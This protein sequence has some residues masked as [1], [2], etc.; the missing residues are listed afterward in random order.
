MVCADCPHLEREE[1][2]GHEAFYRCMRPGEKEG[3]VVA[4][5]PDWCTAAQIWKAPAWCGYGKVD[6]YDIERA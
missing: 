3:R 6:D 5:V 2:P 4:Q 1:C